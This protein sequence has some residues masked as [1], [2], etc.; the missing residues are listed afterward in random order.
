MELMYIRAIMY[1]KMEIRAGKSVLRI[2]FYAKDIYKSK[3]N[4]IFEY[5]ICVLRSNIEKK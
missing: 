4:N 1:V 3:A 5:I 2:L